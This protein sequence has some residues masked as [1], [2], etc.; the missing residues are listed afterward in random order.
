M[1]GFS[2]TRGSR[3]FPPPAFPRGIQGVDA[4]RGGSQKYGLPLWERREGGRERE[5][6]RE[7][8]RK[9]K[10]KRKRGGKR[11]FFM[12]VPPRTLGVHL[13]T[14]STIYGLM[15]EQKKKTE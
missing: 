10:R 11:L 3:E 12:H 15:I 9:R 2:E 7:R 4:D 13:Q 5:R 14:I 6:E 1:R 8:K